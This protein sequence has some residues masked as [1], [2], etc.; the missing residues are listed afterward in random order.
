MGRK[1]LALQKLLAKPGYGNFL[2]TAKDEFGMAQATVYD[3]INE[4]K[5]ADGLYTVRKVKPAPDLVPL[6]P[7]DGTLD[8]VEQAIRDYQA[9]FT[10]A[11]ANAASREYLR[12]FNW[13][14]PSITGELATLLEQAKK[15]LGN[16]RAALVL[17]DAANNLKEEN[18]E[19]LAA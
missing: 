12:D 15:K 10:V 11:E 2:K 19:L 4:A 6:D 9:S 1:L 13:K 7:N 16:E 14:F 5:E 18:N 17:I 8:D 3:Y